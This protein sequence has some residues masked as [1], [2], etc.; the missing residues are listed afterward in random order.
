MIREWG[1]GH[2]VKQRVPFRITLMHAVRFC[3]CLP[4]L[5][6]LNIIPVHA[7]LNRL[8]QNAATRNRNRLKLYGHIDSQL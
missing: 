2:K 6:L 3:D 7:S 1:M 4:T 5:E 8:S